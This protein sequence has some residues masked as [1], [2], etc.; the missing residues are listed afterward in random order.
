MN[1]YEILVE[2]GI[3]KY[4]SKMK[5]RILALTLLSMLLI[6]MFATSFIIA[7]DADDL[8]EDVTEE[9]DITEDQEIEDEAEEEVIEEL[10]EVYN[11]K[12]KIPGLTRVTRVNGWISQDNNAYRMS[13]IWISMRI[14]NAKESDNVEDIETDIKIIKKTFGR[15][16][17]DGRNYKLVKKEF[18]NK[19]LSFYVIPVKSVLSEENIKDV[20][21]LSIGVLEVSP[22]GTKPLQTWTGTLDIDEVVSENEAKPGRVHAGTWDVT[23]A[24]N[25]KVIRG[26]L[27]KGFWQ[28]FLFWKK[29]KAD[30]ASNA[31]LKGIENAEAKRIKVKGEKPSPDSDQ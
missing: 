20:A 23:A 1:A 15:L 14:P 25:T 7:Q 9:V 2:R 11:K 18:T 10:E 30:V 16:K 6:G 12:K 3:E 21:S 22:Q 26:K 13:A 24:G 27:R 31:S 19:S 17:L 8:L 5:T 4:K 28:R 29:E